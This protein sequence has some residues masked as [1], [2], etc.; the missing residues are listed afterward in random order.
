MWEGEHDAAG[1]GHVRAGGGE[2]GEQVCV[3]AGGEGGWGGG[4]GEG[5]RVGGRGREGGRA[6]V[7]EGRGGEG[8]REGE[9]GRESG[10]APLLCDFLGELVRV[11]ALSGPLPPLPSPSLDVGYTSKLSSNSQKRS[12][13]SSSWRMFRRQ[14]QWMS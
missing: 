10:R 6:G 2:G 3:S 8:G 11:L 5:G 13:W 4:G 1:S 7:M 14:T 9:E 12:P